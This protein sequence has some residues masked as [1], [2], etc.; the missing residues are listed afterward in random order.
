MVLQLEIIIVGAKEVSHLE[1]LLF[2]LVITVG[3]QQL[4]D[5]AG[6]ARRERDESFTMAFKQFHIDARLDVKPLREG[7]ADELA[8]V[9]VPGLVFAQQDE[10]VPDGIGAVLH[11]ES[12]TGRDVHLAAYDWLDARLDASLKKFTTPYIAP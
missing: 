3:Q 7:A 2:S 4:R 10:M 1:R 6:Q 11:I 5:L 9:F 12:G 8:E